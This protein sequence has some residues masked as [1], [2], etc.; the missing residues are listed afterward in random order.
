MLEL[1]ITELKAQLFSYRDGD[2]LIA[3]NAAKVLNPQRLLLF[4]LLQGFGFNET[5]VDDLISALDK[6]SGRVFESDSF[7][8][9]VD[10]D[11]LII[12]PKIKQNNR[13]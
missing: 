2:V 9:I 7:T 8:L 5:A 1:R 6:H 13:M 12:T 10:R 3:I 11:N 4:K